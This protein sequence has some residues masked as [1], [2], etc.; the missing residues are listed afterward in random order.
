[1][2]FFLILFLMENRYFIGKRTEIRCERLNVPKRWLFENSMRK[3]V[4]VVRN[5]D[6]NAV[7]STKK[8]S[9]FGWIR[10]LI[11]T[12]WLQRSETKA[13][14]LTTKK[15]VI[16]SNF[17]WAHFLLFVSIGLSACIYMQKK[18]KYPL[19]F[20]LFARCDNNVIRPLT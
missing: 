12:L 4:T 2:F 16:D 7:R 19:V 20:A 8:K 3:P 11:S 13:I 6:Y 10:C 9:I 18:T 17:K 14:E 5:D 1:M 15:K